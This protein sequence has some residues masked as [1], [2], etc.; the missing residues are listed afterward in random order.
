MD[1]TSD[2]FGTSGCK[3]RKYRS[4]SGALEDVYQSGAVM[5]P[6]PLVAGIY[7]KGD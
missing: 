6:Y 2:Q 1:L 5:S 7:N 4:K 3:V